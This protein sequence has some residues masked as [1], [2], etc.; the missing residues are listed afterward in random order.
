VLAT[1]AAINW[2]RVIGDLSRSLEFRSLVR[3]SRQNNTV[4][5][6]QGYERTL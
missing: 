3:R 6:I 4:E 5:Q 1:V 2:N